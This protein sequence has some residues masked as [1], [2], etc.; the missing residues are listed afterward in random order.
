[1]TTSHS[2]LRDADVLIEEF[3]SS[4]AYLFPL[5]STA[6]RQ[7]KPPEAALVALKRVALLFGDLQELG[8]PTV[9]LCECDHQAA[10]SALSARYS[11]KQ[12]YATLAAAAEAGLALGDKISDNP[13]SAI[14]DL[15]LLACAVLLPVKV[16]VEGGA[17][18]LDW[19]DAETVYDAA[20]Q[21]LEVLDKPDMVDAGTW[22]SAILFAE[23]D[24]L[25][26][27]VCCAKLLL[28]AARHLPAFGPVFGSRCDNYVEVAQ[29]ACGF[30]T[31]YV[32]GKLNGFHFVHDFADPARLRALDGRPLAQEAERVKAVAQAAVPGM[33]ALLRCNVAE[34]LNALTDVVMILALAPGAKT[35]WEH[36]ARAM[37]LLL[38]LSRGSMP[39]QRRRCVALEP[40][41]K[42]VSALL[43]PGP[44]GLSGHSLRRHHGLAA[45][46]VM[47]CAALAEHG[48]ADILVAC[49]A[50]PVIASCLR[51][52]ADAGGDRA[53]MN[54][55]AV[56]AT[57]VRV[58]LA[59]DLQMSAAALLLPR[60][61]PA[62][63]HQL[64]WR[65]H[66][67]ARQAAEARAQARVALLAQCG[68]A[69]RTEEAIAAS[70]AQAEDAARVAY[71]CFDSLP[72]IAAPSGAAAPPSL[73]ALRM[74]A[75]MRPG[76]SY[77]GCT[78]LWETASEADLKVRVYF[79]K[80]LAPHVSSTLAPPNFP[81]EFVP[82]RKDAKEEGAAAAAVPSKLTLNFFLPHEQQ[83]KAKE[84]DMVLLPAVTGD[85]GVMPGHVPT[86]AQLRPGVITVHHEL[87]KAVDKYF[88]SSGF[89]FVHADSSTDVCAVE[90]VKVEDLDPEAV[91]AGLQDYTAKLASLQAKG[92]DY[93]IAAA[94]IGVEVYSALNAAVA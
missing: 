17:W 86:V 52:T 61:L 80:R 94:Q 46:V 49:S 44:S 60:G 12:P 48:A 65:L 7:D 59:A 84:V 77:L 67:R 18:Q 3:R 51:S 13:L 41:L 93:E 31:E 11:Q 37:M 70:S 58:P 54:G 30:T 35:S 5:D 74:A 75:A 89:A 25:P 76:C 92:D 2:F 39:A 56:R 33:E 9:G 20:E 10:A 38:H 87:D 29:L 62:S 57:A 23:G 22:H 4:A 40:V 55:H 16:V 85:F 73:E 14:P 90:A 47:T 64:R 69:D 66:A 82:V 26:A 81:S 88:V 53:N 15:G 78:T 28:R 68:S 45:V 42:G 63:R 36:L 72:H 50:A 6:C 79:K 19:A 34:P 21:V 83:M 27:A 32:R 24:R 71:E 43:T 91:R 1:M 8:G